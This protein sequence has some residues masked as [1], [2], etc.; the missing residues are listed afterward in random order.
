MA[1]TMAKTIP[2]FTAMTGS[3][4]Q[5]GCP[6]KGYHTIPTKWDFCPYYLDSETYYLAGG[7]NPS[8]KY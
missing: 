6:N 5:S 2:Y 7:F 1:K 4:P 8:E 3:H